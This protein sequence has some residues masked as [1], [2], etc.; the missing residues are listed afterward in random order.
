MQITGHEDFRVQELD[1][2]YNKGRLVI[3]DYA[4]T[5]NY[6]TLSESRACGRNSSMQSVPTAIN[7]FYS[8]KSLN[9]KL[10]YYFIPHEGNLFTD[11]HMMLYR[12][13]QTAGIEFINFN[14]Y[15]NHSIEP[16]TDV[17]EIIIDRE[18]NRKLNRSNNSSFISKTQERIQLYAKTYGANKY[19]STVFGVAL[20]MI[21][22]RPIDVFAVSEQNLRNLPASSLSTFQTIGNISVYNTS[23]RLNRLSA[24]TEETM[25]LRSAAYNFNLLNR[26]GF[27]KCSICGCEIPEIIH[28]AHIW[29]VA[30]IRNC[31]I[32]DNDQ[33][34]SHAISGHN[35][36]WLCHNHHKL[37]DSHIIAFDNE[38][39]CLVKPN[40]PLSH[41]EFISSSVITS[42][43]DKNLL[44]DEFRCYLARR[45]QSVNI[46]G[47]R[48][49]YV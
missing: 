30:E 20:S 29:G 14:V 39:K 44:S 28:G 19:E 25:R 27:K 42:C 41:K 22:D 37:F 48:Y 17:D 8:D 24:D 16:Y 35:G 33:K 2:S 1:E 4:G 15:C 31:D 11:Y 3:L 26:I 47:Y 49:L 36:I 34:Y 46:D 23:L 6:I 32:I 38:G 7:I 10:W 40:L 43:L 18:C 21:A 12:L 13:M 45:Y 5:R 9:K